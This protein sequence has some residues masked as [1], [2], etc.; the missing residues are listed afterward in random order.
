MT[1]DAANVYWTENA[2]GGV[3]QVAKSGGTIT[4]LRAPTGVANSAWAVT[5][6]ALTSQNTP[7]AT[8]YWTNQADNSVGTNAVGGP[9]SNAQTLATS[10][11]TGGG[12]SGMAFGETSP[13]VIYVGD[14]TAGMLWSV[15]VLSASGV[16]GKNVFHATGV[17]GVAKSGIP[18]E[19]FQPYNDVVWTSL[20]GTAHLG[21]S[22][23]ATGT[24]DDSR[25][26][27]SYNGAMYWTASTGNQ[28]WS[29]STSNVNAPGAPVLVSSAESEPWGVAADVVEVYWVNKKS[30]TIRRATHPST[31]WIVTT[32]ATGNA[33]TDIRVDDQAIYWTD[34][35]SGQVMRLAR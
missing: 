9:A 14:S 5:T 20:N 21:S 17:T 22:P 12:S 8:V 29:G 25:Y 24:N 18:F 1:I 35:G 26:V 4:T 3:Y 23:V 13:H 34:T 16:T 31:S 19:V 15:P 33:P 11:N 6:D 10:P 32:I 27:T 2:T 28:V 30:G 7:A